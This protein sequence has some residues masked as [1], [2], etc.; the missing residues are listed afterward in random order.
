M[1]I[2]EVF[3]KKQW[4]FIN[5]VWLRQTHKHSENCITKT[6][7]E[8]LSYFFI[9]SRETWVCKEAE[10]WQYELC[11]L[12][13]RLFSFIF[14]L[15][16]IGKWPEESFFYNKLISEWWIWSLDTAI[17]SLLLSARFILNKEGR[18]K[19]ALLSMSCHWCYMS[20]LRPSSEDKVT[21][22]IN[23]LS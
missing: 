13:L 17:T 20:T 14:Q 7:S 21:F 3:K 2:F 6:L 8:I 5:T 22:C 1:Y 16:R 9:I 19:V 23:V 11:Q 10:L 4:Q 18:Q 15:V 12:H